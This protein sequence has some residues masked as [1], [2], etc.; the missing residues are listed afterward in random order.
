MAKSNLRGPQRGHPEPWLEDQKPYT[1][2][3]R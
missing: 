3:I 2:R 1:Q